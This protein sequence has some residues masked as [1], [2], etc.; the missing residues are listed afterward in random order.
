[1]V[2]MMLLLLYDDSFSSDSLFFF[3]SFR[4][5]IVDIDIGYSEQNGSWFKEAEELLLCELRLLQVEHSEALQC[6]Q[7]GRM[8]LAEQIRLELQSLLKILK[9]KLPLE[10]EEDE[11][12]N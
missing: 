6:E 2:M 7:R 9:T 10:K 5:A 4:L 3:F 1:M 12:S 11:E 8:R